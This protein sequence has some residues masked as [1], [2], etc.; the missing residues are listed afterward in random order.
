MASVVTKRPATD[1]A[2]WSADPHH[3]GRVDD[4]GL[5]QVAIFAPLGIKPEGCVGL[6]FIVLPM[7]IEP[8]TPA[9]SAIRRVR[10]P[11]TPAERSSIPTRWS[12][13]FGL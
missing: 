3:L 7:T 5:H 12:S 9:F 10:Y 8:S 4:A 2:C 6:D 11:L 1:A 13:F